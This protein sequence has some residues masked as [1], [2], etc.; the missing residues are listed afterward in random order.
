MGKGEGERKGGRG[1]G[2]GGKGEKKGGRGEGRE[3]KGGRDIS[4]SGNLRS[5][6]ASNMVVNLEE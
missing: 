5:D 4:L 2:E 3:E 6:L 1:K